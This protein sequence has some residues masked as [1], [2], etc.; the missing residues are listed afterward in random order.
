MF[1]FFYIFLPVLIIVNFQIQAAVQA[2]RNV[3]GLPWP[4][5]P[6][7]KIEG[8]ML[9][10]LQA[11]FGFQVNFSVFWLNLLLHLSCL[12]NVFF[13]FY[14]HMILFYLISER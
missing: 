1:L 10:W 7:V 5:D 4:K 12:I 13:N 14:D 3:R 6:E 8:D 9:D 11:M 2:I